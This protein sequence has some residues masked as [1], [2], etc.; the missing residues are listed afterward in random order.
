MADL[1]ETAPGRTVESA[2]LDQYNKSIEAMLASPKLSKNDRMIL[3][4]QRLFVMFMRA[5]QEDRGKVNIMWRTYQIGY[6]LLWVLVPLFI[7]DIFV[8][9]WSILYPSQNVLGSL[10]GP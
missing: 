9:L 1:N 7:G 4:T 6:R 5:Y 3:E 8:R 10:L 2:L